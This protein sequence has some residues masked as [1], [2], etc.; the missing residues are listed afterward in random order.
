MTDHDTPPAA[1]D[2]VPAIERATGR[3]WADW[4]RIF[5]AAGAAELPHPEIARV[6]LAEM[7]ESL[8]N[9]GWWAQGVAIAFEHQIGLRVP[10]QSST[11]DFRVGA[12]RTL[13]LGRDDAIERWV[14]LF[15]E[16]EHRGHAV[17]SVRRSRTEKRSFWRANLHGAGKLEIAA[18]AK[19]EDRTS[20]TVNHTGLSSP[21]ELESWRA[22]WKHCL[23]SL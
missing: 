13:P 12:S 2:R 3:T 15:G 23:A 19:G 20:V 22:H 18:E 4:L 9:P 21:D 6:A 1:G 14:E 17:E 5:E 16:S 7:P 11:G 10:G 8:E